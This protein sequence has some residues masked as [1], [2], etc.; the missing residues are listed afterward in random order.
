MEVGEQWINKQNTIVEHFKTVP[1]HIKC[2]NMD[3]ISK[4]NTINERK[5]SSKSIRAHMT[6]FMYG[7]QTPKIIPHIV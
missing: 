2:I 3:K 6:L 7:F 4:Y 1:K 5:I